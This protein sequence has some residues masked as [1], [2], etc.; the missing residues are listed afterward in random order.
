MARWLKC[1]WVLALVVAGCAT[2]R[3]TDTPRTATEQLL[4]SAAADYALPKMD[5]SPLAG[6][7]VYLDTSNFEGTD[8]GYVIGAVAGRLNAQG[9][10]IA[11]SAEKA[12]AILALHCGALSTD[13]GDFLLGIPVLEVPLPF[14]GTI[15][16][17]ELALLKR[18]HRVGIV[19]L[20]GHAHDAATGE[21]LL[22]VGPLDGQSRYDMWTIMLVTFDVSNIPEKGGTP[23][24]H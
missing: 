17:P 12:D 13:R 9:A 4:L 8:K 19:K 20:G 24:E 11:P 3:T 2:P 21:H 16:T 10:H 14:G 5:L 22:S 7:K 1:A 23:K 6:K 18:T 15:K